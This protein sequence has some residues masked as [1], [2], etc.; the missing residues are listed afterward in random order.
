VASLV[1]SNAIW[2][3]NGVGLGS[4]PSDL[5]DPAVDMIDA[6]VPVILAST[7]APYGILDHVWEVGTGTFVCLRLAASSGNSLLITWVNA[8][9]GGAREAGVFWLLMFEALE[10]TV[11][12]NVDSIA[13]SLIDVAGARVVR[14][15]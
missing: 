11:Q 14:A 6:A 2:N 9:G 8:L 7:E 12:E 5:I 13:F 3:G 10:L 15:P 1:T 4:I